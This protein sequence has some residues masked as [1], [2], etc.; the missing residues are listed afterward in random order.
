MYMAFRL[1][2]NLETEIVESYYAF[3]T[4]ETFGNSISIFCI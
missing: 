4:W 3:R 2:L 1:K